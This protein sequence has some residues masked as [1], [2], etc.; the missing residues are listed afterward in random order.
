MIFKAYTTLQEFNQSGVEGIM[1]YT[2]EVSP[3][4]WVMVL[5]AL[6]LIIL[7]ATYKGSNSFKSAF[8]VA[9]IISSIVSF[10]LGLIGGIIPSYIVIT[11]FVISIVAVIILLLSGRD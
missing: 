11:F 9:G 7:I 4:F 2:A 3:L 8:A 10:L 6:F 5:I 1:R